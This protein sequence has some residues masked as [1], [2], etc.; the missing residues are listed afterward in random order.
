MAKHG[1]KYRAVSE[2][3]EKLKQYPLKEAVELVKKFAFT[4]FDE[5][6]DLS[7]RLNVD[8]RHAEQMVRGTVI[9]PNG[10]GKTIKILVFA[11][12]EQENEA[13]EAGADFV[14]SDDLAEK[15]QGG[16]TDFD[17]AIASPDMMSI[18]GRLGKILGPRGLMPNPKVGTVT[19]DI[20]KA[21]SEAKAGKIQFRVDKGGNIQAPVGKVSFDADKL[22]ENTQTLLDTIVRA[23]P[24]MVKGQYI[25]NITISST[26]GPGIKIVIDE[27]TKK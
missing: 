26:M 23:R 9:L 17:V 11:K 2:S 22:V 24:A 25:K 20:S 4:K 16:W 27:A 12:G 14:G 8:P 10:T 21:V 13:K 7:I 18:V 5:T 1:K 6:V 19:K 15:I 3:Y